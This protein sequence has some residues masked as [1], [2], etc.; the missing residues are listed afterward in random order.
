MPGSTIVC[1]YNG[2]T[3]TAAELENPYI[4]GGD[5]FC[6]ECYDE[7]YNEHS[8]ACAFC[9]E[10]W[11]EDDMSEWFVL[12]DAEYGDPGLYRPLSYPYCSQKALLK[13]AV[14][15]V[16]SLLPSFELNSCNPMELVCEKCVTGRLDLEER[17]R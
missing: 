15:R 11:L 16:G 1:S 4:G 10:Y 12:V 3:L 6:E 5:Q 8:V 2:C 13:H 17:A 14:E 7:W 9:E